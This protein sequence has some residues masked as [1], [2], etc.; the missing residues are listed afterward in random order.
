MQV[1]QT[2]IPLVIKASG[3]FPNTSFWVSNSKINYHLQR[4]QLPLLNYQLLQI[5]QLFEKLLY[6]TGN[7]PSVHFNSTEDLVD[8]THFLKE[9]K[10]NKKWYGLPRT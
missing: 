10:M 4:F 2:I 3:G 1:S 8:K 7:E 5:Y 6:L 9:T